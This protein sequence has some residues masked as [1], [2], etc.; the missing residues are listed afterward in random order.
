MSLLIIVFAVR[1]RFLM[2]NL[3]P[4]GMVDHR[5]LTV[6]GKRLISTGSST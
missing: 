6:S 5:S 4:R 2:V 3:N 1:V